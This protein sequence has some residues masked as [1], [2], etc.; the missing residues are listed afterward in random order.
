M[1]KSMA[2]RIIACAVATFSF[3]TISDAQVKPG[4]HITAR[5]AAQVKDLVSPGTYFAVSKGMA[6][7]IV[8]PERVEWPPP[9]KIATEQYSS[10]V[11]LSADHR[12]VLGYVAGQ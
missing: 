5:N 8:A 6:M 9:F 10:Q 4:D 12:T 7:N 1:I 3:A 11:R 2:A